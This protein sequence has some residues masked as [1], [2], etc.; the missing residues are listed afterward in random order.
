MLGQ[1]PRIGRV[2]HALAEPDQQPQRQQRGEAGGQA[3]Q[4]RRAGPERQ[5]DRH[6]PAHVEAL[7]DRAGQRVRRGVRPEERREQQAHLRAR[8]LQLV[9]E[10]RR[11]H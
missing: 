3:A 1:N 4:R 6:H 2:D 9:G 7:G 5:A 10:H 11:G 8:D